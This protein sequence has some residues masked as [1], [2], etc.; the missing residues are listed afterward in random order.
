MHSK[1]KIIMAKKNKTEAQFVQVEEAV[2]KT[3]QYIIDNQK[4]LTTILSVIIGIIVLYNVYQNF[5]IK[6]LEE[7]AK[8][9]MFMAELYFQKDSFNLALNGD[10][11]YYGFLDISDEYSEYLDNNRRYNYWQFLDSIGQKKLINSFQ[12]FHSMIENNVSQNYIVSGLSNLF[13]NIYAKNIYLDV[14]SDFPIINK[15][16]LRNLDRYCCIYTSEESLSVLK[17]LYEIDKMIKSFK[18]G[19]NYKIELLILK[20]CYEQKR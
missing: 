13:F 14:G 5:Y 6:P 9:E 19:V 8:S 15:I 18:Y 12:I 17:D 16:L 2:S 3:E 7:E 4:S 1:N 20:V 10:G 11:Q